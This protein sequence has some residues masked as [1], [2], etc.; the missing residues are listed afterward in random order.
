MNRRDVQ[1]AEEQENN[2]R[3]VAVVAEIETTTEVVPKE[4]QAAQ[5][6]SGNRGIVLR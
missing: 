6:E 4:M 2:K 5:A 1:T 3:I